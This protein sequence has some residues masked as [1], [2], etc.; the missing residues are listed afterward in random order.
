MIF[1]DRNVILKNL[2]Y[3]IKE[4]YGLKLGGIGPT[5]VYVNFMNEDAIYVDFEQSIAFLA[6]GCTKKVAKFAKPI[7]DD[8][9]IIINKK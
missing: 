2:R 5:G 6:V 4:S 7:V 9:N 8:L 1:M 3:F